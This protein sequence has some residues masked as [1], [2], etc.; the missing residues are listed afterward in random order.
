MGVIMAG[1]GGELQIWNP[2]KQIS[3]QITLKR[4]VAH[5]IAMNLARTGIPEEKSEIPS[6]HNQRIKMRFKGLNEIVSAQ[7]NLV[8]ISK[9]IVG[10]SDRR[11]WNRKYKEDK[12]KEEHP[13]SKED[14]DYNELMAILIF[15]DECEQ[16]I[17]IARR[18]KKL[19]DDFVWE[20]QDNNNG[21]IMLEL[22]PNF[23]KIMKEL[24]SS[25]EGI[26]DVML[27]NKIVSSGFSVDE[28]ME[29]KQK[30]EEAVRRIVES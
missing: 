1:E 13:F 30:E 10:N 26:Y 14:N 15:L 16:R 9:A 21:E 6:T 18:T 22:S 7:Q 19:D 3:E 12:E 24:E 28:E 29:D 25:Y 11:K 2:D 23:F 5:D 20:K 27:T 17:I 8:N 4:I